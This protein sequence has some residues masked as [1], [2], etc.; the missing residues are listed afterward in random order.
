MKDLKKFLI[1]LQTFKLRQIQ[2]KVAVGPYGQ[3]E[4]TCYD[5][6]HETHYDEAA[7]FENKLRLLSEMA[8]LDLLP[9]NYKQL[10]LFLE[11]TKT[12]EKRFV[13]FW[14]NFHNHTFDY[15]LE[16]PP[17]YLYLINLPRLFV[18]HNLQPG[19]DTI[20]IREE[21]VDD[22]SESVKL[23]ES[24]L[25]S[26][27]RQ[28]KSLLPEK[29][30]QELPIEEPAPARTVSASPHFVD[31]VTEKLYEILKGYFTSED[32]QPLLSLLQE[33]RIVSSPLLFHGNGN[34]LADAF[35]QLYEANLIV[36]CLKGELEAWIASNFAYVYRKQQRTL[37]PNYLAAIISSNAK[38]CQSP[39]LDV[40]K[41]PDG[42]YTVIPVVRTQKNYTIQ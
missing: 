19:I 33:N 36:G 13:K 7:V 5:L 40:R 15:G 42:T 35:K 25:A 32:Q 30:E 39:I 22:L 3:K 29:E 31:G 16:Y 8:A 34:Q 17:G 9:L 37:P 27:I 6:R 24:M 26:L 10:Q 20:E 38:P 18:I 28:V 14:V 23:R 4:V 21:F 1:R 2:R 41:Q 11:Q 12:I